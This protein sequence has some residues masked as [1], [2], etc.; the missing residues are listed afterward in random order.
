MFN[1]GIIRKIFISLVLILIVGNAFSQKNGQN[2]PWFFIQLT[3]PQFGMFEN[4]AGYEKETALYENAVNSI[5]KLNPDF[6]VITGDL[7]NDSKSESQINEFK[8]IT[9]KINKGIPVYFTPGNHDLGNI[10]DGQSVMKFKKEFG[11]DKFTFK[12]KG[13][14]F[15]GFNTSFIKS[16]MQPDEKNQYN[17]LTSELDKA[18]KATHII[19][20]C[21][22][23]FFNKA[24]DEPEAYSNIG[25]AYREKYLSLFESH[26]VSAVFSGHYHNN[27][28]NQ[29]KGIQMI[30]TSALGK[31]LGKA[32]SGMRIVKIYPD[33]IEHEYVGLEEVPDKVNLK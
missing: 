15:I 14:V 29:Y 5:N 13:S 30:T 8:R 31:P 27:A 16:D 25:S 23:P 1:K 11:S 4:N 28:I 24:A 19:L 2:T 20:F 7:V 21:H 18:L 33:K 10:P 22:Y 3:D 12:H 32:P 26:K 9:S 6:V 17:W